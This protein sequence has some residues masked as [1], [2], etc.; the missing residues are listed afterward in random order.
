MVLRTS[1]LKGTRNLSVGTDCSGLKT[2][3]SYCIEVNNSLPYESDI[4]KTASNPSLPTVT[5]KPSPIGS[6]K[7]NGLIPTPTNGVS[8]LSPIQDGIVKNYNKFHKIMSITMCANIENYY[9][10]PLKTFYK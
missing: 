6:A 5:I 7:P 8:T 10:L 4:L 9:K 3:F 2:G 1:A